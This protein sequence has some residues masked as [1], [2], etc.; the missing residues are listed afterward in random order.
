VR[1]EASVISA[2]LA[3]TY[4][5]NCSNS[6][7]VN[8][9]FPPSP[10]PTPVPEF[11]PLP[12]LLPPIPSP[13]PE[14]SSTPGLQEQSSLKLELFVKEIE[15]GTE[16]VRGVYIKNILALHIVQQPKHKNTDVTLIPGAVSQFRLAEEVGSIGLLGR[17]ESVGK[18]F[19]KISKGEEV[20]VINGK[21]KTT[22]YKVS[23]I[24]KFKAFEP[25]NPSSN[26][27]QLDE[28]NKPIKGTYINA[29][30]LFQKIYSARNNRLVLQTCF[31]RDEGRIFFIAKK[32][33][34]TK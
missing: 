33:E 9:K 22:T 21:G 16:F 25:D 29:N 12:T 3:L 17:S 24:L 13:T 1:K 20:I 8:I 34:E 7:K 31:D 18:N 15:D 10:A 11:L 6:E 23:E 32:V 14:L 26:F 5:F 2:L 19:L 30:N 4:T 28:D 27:V